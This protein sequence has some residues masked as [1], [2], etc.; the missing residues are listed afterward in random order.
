MSQVVQCNG[1]LYFSGCVSAPQFVSLKDQTK[2]ILLTLQE[3]LRKYGSNKQSIL[4]A[5][6]HLK[7]IKQ[8]EEMN[9]VWDSWVEEG[10]APARTCVEAKMAAED[11]LVE[12]TIVAALAG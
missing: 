5:L 1:I 10:H 2:S 12:I 8:F 11:I 3:L 7:D 9:S 6:I 4:S